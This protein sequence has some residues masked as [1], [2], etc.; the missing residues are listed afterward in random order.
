MADA[1]LRRAKIRTGDGE[2]VAKYLPPGYRVVGVM[3]SQRPDG[4]VYEETTLIEGQD[5]L[6]WTLDDYVLPRL[7]SGGLFGEEVDVG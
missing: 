1:E 4:S 6:G 2:L 7:A 3:E 5:H